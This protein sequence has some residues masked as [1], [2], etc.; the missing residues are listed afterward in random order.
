MSDY[1]TREDADMAIKIA[2]MIADK[3]Y[4]MCGD[5]Y[6]RRYKIMGVIENVLSG[7]GNTHV[8]TEGDDQLARKIWAAFEPMRDFYIEKKVIL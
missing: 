6:E 8:V 4:D 7:R 5:D 3:V 1:M 2:H